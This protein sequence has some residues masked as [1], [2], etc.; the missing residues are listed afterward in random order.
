[1]LKRV[2]NPQNP[3][4]GEYCEWIDAPESKLEIFEERARSIISTN[5]SPDISF[6]YSVNPYRG[7][8][9]ACA[10]CYARRT[11]Q[12]LDFGAGT[13]FERKIVI[14]V[15]AA[16]LLEKELRKE[17]WN[18]DML[19]FS[20]VTDCYQP[21]E[22]TYR[23][24]QRCLEACSRYSNPVTVITK[25]AIVRRDADL[26]AEL[27][28]KAGASVAISIPFAD[29]AM[30]KIIEPGAPRSSTRFRAMK[31]LANRGIPVGI[32]IAPVIPGLS[33]EGIP[34]L[35]EQAKECGAEF[36]FMT[37]LR[38]PAEVEDV[39]L[40]RL[41]EGVPERYGKVVGSLK[42]MR[43]GEIYKSD[44]GKRMSGEGERW[45][46]LRWLFD[47]CCERLELNKRRSE[48]AE[49]RKKGR[50]RPAQLQLF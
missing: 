10:Y 6:S 1:M 25:S 12:Y 22:L 3:F 34:K 21:L 15:N 29:D 40:T 30:A 8:F 49:P 50:V 23:L 9:H 4:H 28:E 14:K 13:D 24:T 18:G 45:K 19:V 37:L 32:G 38:L 46:A 17:S 26:L 33:D 35:L 20:G 48:D 11:H 36:A 43:G 16:E 47:N 42:A 31:E 27:H 5:D 39:F 44:F 7:C 2:E 41:H